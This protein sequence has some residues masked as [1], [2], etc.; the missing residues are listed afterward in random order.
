[1]NQKDGKNFLKSDW[2][3][4]DMK[5]TDQAKGIPMPPFEDPFNAEDLIPLPDPKSAEL[6]KRDFVELVSDRRSRRKLGEGNVK[7]SE[8]SFVLWAS[9]GFREVIGKRIFR[10][11]PSAGSRH[12]FETYIYADRVEGLEKGLY[13][14]IGT[15]NSLIKVQADE[16]GQIKDTLSKAMLKQWFNCAFSL[17]WVYNAYRCEW[18]YADRSYRVSAYD[19]GHIC[20]NAYLAAEA[21]EIGC[22]AIGAFMQEEIDKCIGVDG[23]NEFVCYIGVFGP[24]KKRD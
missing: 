10:T 12:P 14:Y 20:Q 24:Y 5:D 15:E 17:L 4:N 1:M 11:V 6:K 9:H 2:I 22:C 19:A 16:E 21:I 13:R 8:L 7:L 23:E 18:R 3:P